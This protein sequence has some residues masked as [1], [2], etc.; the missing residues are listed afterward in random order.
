MTNH[1]GFGGKGHDA[2][3]MMNIN[4]S[5]EDGRIYNEYDWVWKWNCCEKPDVE[6]PKYKAYSPK[7]SRLIE[8]NFMKFRGGD[9]NA[10]LV[11][12]NKKYSVNVSHAV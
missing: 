9:K 10:M 3:H 6:P 2:E 7:T 5:M 11:Q 1:S 4:T 8:Q 12:I